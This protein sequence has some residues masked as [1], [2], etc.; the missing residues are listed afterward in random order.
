MK[1]EEK[2]AY[3]QTFGSLAPTYLQQG[4]EGA[5]GQ[6]EAACTLARGLAGPT[7]EAWVVVIDD[8][9]KSMKPAP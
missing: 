8:N 1:A 7:R 5:G 6:V 2:E 9:I 3:E 4:L